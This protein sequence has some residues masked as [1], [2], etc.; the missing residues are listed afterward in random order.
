MKVYFCR[1][2]SGHPTIWNASYPKPKKNEFGE[3]DAFVDEGPNLICDH[4]EECLFKP[5]FHGVRK[6]RCVLMELEPNQ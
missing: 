2:D 5:G 3:W 6:G 1:D 4:E